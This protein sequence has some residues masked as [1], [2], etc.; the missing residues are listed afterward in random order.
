MNGLAM[1][2]VYL[3]LLVLSCWW[4]DHCDCLLVWPSEGDIVVTPG[5]RNCDGPIS[6]PCEIFNHTTLYVSVQRDV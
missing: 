3:S 2:F 5:H 1:N 4:L 6:I